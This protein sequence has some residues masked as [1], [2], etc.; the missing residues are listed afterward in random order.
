MKV[1]VNWI[2]QFI[3]FE[4]PPV[5]EL[6]E[7]IG[8]QLGGVDGVE[9]IGNK[10]KGAIIAKVIACEP[11]SDSDHLNVCR[12]D[13]GGAA[14]HVERGDDGLV[15]VVCGAPNVRPGLTV[16]WLP[17]GSTVPESFGKNP[18]VLGARELRGVMSN[19]MLASAKELAI[20]DN[21]EGIVEIEDNTPAG[22]SFVEAFQLDDYIIDIENKMFTHRPDCFGQ[23][24]IAREIAGI[25]GKPFKSPDWVYSA[26]LDAFGVT[27]QPLSLAVVNE[28]PNLVPRFMAVAMSGI[29]IKPSPF[30]FQTWLARLGVRP[31]SNV[32]DVTNYIMLLTGQPL[33]AYDYDKLSSLSGENG[34]TI[35]IRHPR[36]NEEISLLN[37]K[38]IKP[39]EEAIM[40][41]T[42]KQLIGVGGAMGGSETEVDENTKAIVLEVATF[43]M[44]SIRRTSMAHG[45]FTE[46]VTRFNKGQ[47]PLQND[48]V[49]TESVRLLEK[50]SGAQMASEIIDNN[51]VDQMRRERRWVHPPVPVAV[52]FV[53][54]RLGFE[55]S[56]EAIKAL[57]ENVEFSVDVN[58]NNLTVTAPFWRTDVETREDVVEEVGRLYGFDK[59][60]LE[61]PKRSIQPAKRD[62]SFDLKATIRSELSRAGANEVLT[63][64]FVHGDLLEKVGQDVSQAY[65]VSNALS[66]DLQFYRLGLTP[67]L[68]EKVHLN[69]K[70]GYDRFALFELGKV[71]GKSETDDDGLPKEFERLGF[72][73]AA[74]PKTAVRLYGGAPFYAAR[75]FAQTIAGK[76]RTLQLV[77]LAE[78][79]LEGHELTRQM[80]APYEPN[81]SAVFCDGERIVGVVGEFKRSVSRAF[82]LPE[83]C[84]GFELFLGA[85]TN[86]GRE[87]YVPLPRYPEV[88]Q[89]ITL[90]VAAGLNYQ[91]LYDV[92][93]DEVQAKK[94]DQTLVALRPLDIYQ[95]P[96]DTGHKQISFRLDIASYVTTLTD[97]EVATFLGLVAN[98]AKEKCGAEQI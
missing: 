96:D 64:S 98:A 20:G 61:L 28:V 97:K 33:H 13:D 26:H 67:S 76:N 54:S 92:L 84:A 93:W 57:L 49:L 12:I 16:V 55:L 9:Y 63:Y 52:G 6:V 56:A 77:P 68:L 42:D 78:A 66:P 75:K 90:K 80:V 51:H 14:Q 47:S 7:K 43:D 73:V 2:K 30:E 37:G 29:T 95:R 44:Y 3:D 50:L 82:K 35:A 53:N 45:L 8:A 27:G 88:T 85:L 5:E 1:S 71:H 74:E 15:Q 36:S 19:G 70:A 72:V 25:L 10:Y 65:Q 18:F 32:V 31:I 4:L 41:A 11:H 91:A 21:H 48:E 17:P 89:D 23:L 22:A 83:F 94:P 58:E 59:L 79:D 60:P 40:I 24:G 87:Q 38:T 86:V 62:K 46:A 69:V 34:A 39:R 81:R